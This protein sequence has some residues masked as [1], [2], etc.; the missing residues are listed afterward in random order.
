MILWFISDLLEL[1]GLEK[2]SG[3]L[4]C[5]T[6]EGREFAKVLKRLL[7]EA[8]EEYWESGQ[9]YEPVLDLFAAD[10]RHS[11]TVLPCNA[12]GGWFARA[13]GAEILRQGGTYEVSYADQDEY[14]S[15]DGAIIIRGTLRYVS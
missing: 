1:M 11:A 7:D 8:C 3:K 4:A 12:Q 2:A 6:S 14:G 9:Y 13:W 15:D 5:L 10:G